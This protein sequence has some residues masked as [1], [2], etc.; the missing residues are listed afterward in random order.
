MYRSLKKLLVTNQDHVA[1]VLYICSHKDGFKAYWSKI[2]RN[3]RILGV[4]TA[5]IGLGCTALGLGLNIWFAAG[6]GMAT[7]VIGMVL[8]ISIAILEALTMG[9][10]EMLGELERG[11]VAA[12]KGELGDKIEGKIDDEKNYLVA[13]AGADDVNL[14][15][16]ER[17]DKIVDKHS[18]LMKK[19]NASASMYAIILCLVAT[20]GFLGKFVVTIPDV[21]TRML[22]DGLIIG[23]MD[24]TMTFVNL[25]SGLGQRYNSM[26]VD[27]GKATTAKACK[28]VFEDPLTM[29]KMFDNVEQNKSH[30]WVLFANP[31]DDTLVWGSLLGIFFALALSLGSTIK[32]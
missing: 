30:V 13:D 20:S 18:E 7:F 32:G 8:V 6:W 3:T 25:L 11:V 28:E 5:V 22:G 19:S 26:L 14:S 1:S 15:N 2:D 10:V 21:T 27:T 16:E 31:V 23:T 12:I 17:V 29:K 24:V 9:H 4:G